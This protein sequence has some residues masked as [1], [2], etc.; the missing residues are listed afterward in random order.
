MSN[1]SSSRIRFCLTERRNVKSM[2]YGDVRCAA[3]VYTQHKWHFGQCETSIR[4]KFEPVVVVQFAFVNVIP[5]LC[6]HLSGITSWRRNK[7]Q[8]QYEECLSYANENDYNSRI[9]R[10]AELQIHLLCYSFAGVN[11]C[12]IYSMN[13]IEI[14]WTSKI[15]FSFIQELWIFVKFHWSID[16][17]NIFLTAAKQFADV[18]TMPNNTSMTIICDVCIHWNE[19]S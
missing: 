8:K 18:W 6:L 15:W 14:E 11:R 19:Q 12:S 10:L 13:N 3:S 2:Y 5:A 17:S 7:K 1:T 4:L 9:S 16:K